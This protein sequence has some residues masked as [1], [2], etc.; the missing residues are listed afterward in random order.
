MEDKKFWMNDKY[1]AITLKIENEKQN[2]LDWEFFKSKNY[3]DRM[4]DYKYSIKLTYG[5]NDGNM[6]KTENLRYFVDE[7]IKQRNSCELV[8]ADGGIELKTDSEY[9]LQE[10]YNVKLFFSEAI[11]AFACQKIDGVFIMK[12]YESFFDNTIDILRLLTLYYK[13]VKI[14]KPHMSRPAS[15]ERLFFLEFKKSSIIF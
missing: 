2:A 9:A 11:T 1:Y 14:T 6:L 5:K 13:K 4:K 8:T 12:I 3:F 15:S 10:L 7:I